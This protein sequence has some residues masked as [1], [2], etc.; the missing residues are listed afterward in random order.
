MHLV[1]QDLLAHFVQ[2]V[3]EL[4]G[5]PSTLAKENRVRIRFQPAID[6]QVHCVT[7]PG[8]QALV[9]WPCAYWQRFLYRFNVA[10]ASFL[11]PPLQ[12]REDVENV[13]DLSGYSVEFRL[14][15]VN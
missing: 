15:L 7:S 11:Q 13:S 9:F 1:R 6:E 8:L 14:S 12:V 5:L 3:L 10:E 2:Q 4:V